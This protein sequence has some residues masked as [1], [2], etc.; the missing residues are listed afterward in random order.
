MVRGN[1]GHILLNQWIDQLKIALRNLH[2]PGG[3]QTGKTYFSKEEAKQHA[4]GKEGDYKRGPGKCGF[5]AG[6]NPRLFRMTFND[7][8][9]TPYFCCQSWRRLRSFSPAIKQ[10]VKWIDWSGHDLNPIPGLF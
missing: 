10:V 1:F 2:A 3:L 7:S 5:D 4:C 6:K 9:T 8:D